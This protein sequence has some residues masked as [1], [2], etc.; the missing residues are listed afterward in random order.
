VARLP[1]S[2]DQR[3][4]LFEGTSPQGMIFHCSDKA[5]SLHTCRVA[6]IL[7]QQRRGAADLGELEWAFG[8]HKYFLTALAHSQRAL[9]GAHSSKD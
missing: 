1:R 9:H 8:Q 6:L 5:A 3:L 4:E 7:L 2:Y